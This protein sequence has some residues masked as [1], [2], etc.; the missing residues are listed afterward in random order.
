VD[1]VDISKIFQ[2][3]NNE[4]YKL[5]TIIDSSPLKNWKT[6]VKEY[7]DFRFEGIKFT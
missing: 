6:L 7:T 1:R 4:Y 2:H 5:L 3:D